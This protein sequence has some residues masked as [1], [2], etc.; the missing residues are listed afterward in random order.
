MEVIDD[1]DH[2]T[3]TS[4]APQTK[5]FT[6]P[7]QI[8]AGTTTTT[9][10][11]TVAI[12]ALWLDGPIQTET[13][14]DI[15]EG[16]HA[17]VVAGSNDVAAVVPSGAFS[18]TAATVRRVQQ[19]MTRN[20]RK[21]QQLRRASLVS[22]AQP[23]DSK[24][25]S[26][27]GEDHHHNTAPPPHQQQRRR[28]GGE[29]NTVA[30]AA[31]KDEHKIIDD[32][33]NDDDLVDD[34]FAFETTKRN[35]ST[36]AVSRS[37]GGPP[38][39]PPQQSLAFSS[40]SYDHNNNDHQQKQ[41]Q[42][43]V[44]KR[45]SITTNTTGTLHNNNA[46]NATGT[47]GSSTV[48]S[49]MMLTV[50]AA[51]VRAMQVVFD[52]F[53]SSQGAQQQRRTGEDNHHHHQLLQTLNTSQCLEALSC[54]GML[55]DDD[56]LEDLFAEVKVSTGPA[57]ATGGAEGE[58]AAALSALLTKSMRVT[59]ISVSKPFLFEEE[60][61][62]DEDYDDD[63]DAKQ[64]TTSRK[65][66][67]KK[68]QQRRVNFDEF[69]QL[70]VII[71]SAA[72]FRLFVPRD[73]E[74]QR[75]LDRSRSS[76]FLLP[77]SPVMWVWNALILAVTIVAFWLAVVT[78]TYDNI[79]L[80]KFFS[81]TTWMEVMITIMFGVDIVVRFFVASRA[82]A[83]DVGEGGGGPTSNNDGDSNNSR[84]IL[85]D[86]ARAIALAYVKSYFILDVLAMLP[87]RFVFAFGGSSV[88]AH[89]N[90]ISGTVTNGGSL[91]C[92]AISCWT[93]DGLKS[94]MLWA[95]ILAHF[96][97]LKVVGEGR[98]YKESSIQ[99]ITSSYVT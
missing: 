72:R 88:E 86:T 3:T 79:E 14:G 52:Q 57:T 45:A 1:D 15:V 9:E 99:P 38:Q 80:P 87:L 77:D 83:V 34:Y 12:D 13:K 54:F 56:Q 91:G 93:E 61:T 32:H 92:Q 68:K 65:K 53:A 60:D 55:L 11:P 24:I 20:M 51:G 95:K 40:S 18:R 89:V 22:V 8:P 29:S 48:D 96:R 26:G 74:T 4:S 97:I 71:Q 94:A 73:E 67:K 75:R 10:Q 76:T 84:W 64:T 66:T 25:S 59:E 98:Y 5:I 35:P 69:L 7:L 44:S 17:V 36:I 49:T 85:L 28:S 43:Q 31:S 41:Q 78:H 58:E 21:Q 63:N 2:T 90:F 30:T 47:M 33:N 6:S 42:L 16:N 27:G 46:A 50:G 23:R 37:F 70:V 39:P 81:T 82:A 62:Y 19:H